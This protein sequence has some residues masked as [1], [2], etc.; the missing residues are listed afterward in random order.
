MTANRFRMLWLLSLV[1]L[2]LTGLPACEGSKISQENFDKIRT[3]MIQAEVQG[4]L[5]EPT[6]SSS[7]DI[8]GFSGT[9]S[10][11]KWQD[12]TI[13]I[14]LLNGKVVSKQM[15]KGGK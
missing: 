12:T 6:D 8:A 15:H 4:I 2:I 7:V 9:A 1:V 10:V 3:G 11:W 14:Q 13:T 5:G